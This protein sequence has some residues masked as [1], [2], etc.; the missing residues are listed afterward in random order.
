MSGERLRADRREVAPGFGDRLLAAL[1]R[2]GLAIARR[3]V[4]GERE[5]FRPVLDAHDGGIAARPLHRVAEDDVVVLL[6]DPALRAEI[7]RADQ[8]FQQRLGDVDIGG[9]TIVGGDHRP[10]RRCRR[11]AGRIPAPRRRAP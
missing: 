1:E 11:T 5:A 7:G 2:I 10:L 3:H 6:P 9:S 4:G 8:Q